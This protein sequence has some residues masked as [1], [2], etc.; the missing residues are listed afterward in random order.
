MAYKATKDTYGFSAIRDGLGLAH[1]T[2]RIQVMAGDEFPPGVEPEDEAAVER[3]ERPPYSVP[4]YPPES[5]TLDPRLKAAREGKQDEP[6]ESPK[7]KPAS[8]V[9][10]NK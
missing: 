4:G 7:A 3:F 1:V 10:G 9:K 5:I 6:S 8:Q 2:Q